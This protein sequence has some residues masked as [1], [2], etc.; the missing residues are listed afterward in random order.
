MKK[1]FSIGKL[2][3][4]LNRPL[5]D[6]K[7]FRDSLGVGSDKHSG[8]KKPLVLNITKVR[9]KSYSSNQTN[10]LTK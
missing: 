5:I 8:A 2:R 3:L 1:N 10:N 7:N 4:G 6:L 9:E